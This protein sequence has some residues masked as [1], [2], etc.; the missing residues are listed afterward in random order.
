MADKTTEQG[1]E[2]KALYKNKRYADALFDYYYVHGLITAIAACPEIPLPGQWMAWVLKPGNLALSNRQQDDIAH[3]LMTTL[4]SQ[5]K[6]MTDQTSLLPNE[7][8]FDDNQLQKV[9][10]HTARDN[11]VSLW[12]SGVLA[13]HAQ[14]EKV[15]LNAWNNMLAQKP[16]EL[17]PLQ[18]QLKHVLSMLSTFANIP[19][20]IEQAEK[21]GNEQLKTHLPMIARALPNTIKDYVALSGSLVS[22]LEHQF[23]T[24]VKPNS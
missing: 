6:R 11:P 9:N 3:A 14:L 20:A 2:L 8:I 7:A 5:L 22:Y 19:L 21:K 16:E 15:W 24:F 18:K 17:V 1:P 10:Q 23:E 4:Q 13:G 12:C